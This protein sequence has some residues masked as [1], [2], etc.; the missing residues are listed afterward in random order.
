MVKLPNIDLATIQDLSDNIPPGDYLA[1]VI[2]IKEAT[3]KKGNPMLV[4]HWKIVSG[5]YSSFRIQSYTTI[6]Y[7]MSPAML[8][9][10]LAFSRTGAVNTDTNNLVGK[11][12]CLVVGT[13]PII[14]ENTGKGNE[15]PCVIAVFSAEAFKLNHMESRPKKEER[16]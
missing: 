8:I 13:R 10:L 12:A 2:D 1:E 15:Y 11:S 16:K 7:P 3:S 5:F 9:H 6:E 14:R 4:W